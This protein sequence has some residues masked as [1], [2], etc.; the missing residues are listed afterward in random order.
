MPEESLAQGIEGEVI[1]TYTVILIFDGIKK[2]YMDYGRIVIIE[3]A[4]I[5]MH[6]FLSYTMGMVRTDRLTLFL[7]G[8]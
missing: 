7:L 4:L 5:K 2:T 6:T 1:S 8:G 3:Y